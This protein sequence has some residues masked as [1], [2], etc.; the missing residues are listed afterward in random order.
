[1]LVTLAVNQTIGLGTSATYTYSPQSVQKI[2]VRV[3]DAD[4]ESGTLNVQIGSKTIVNSASLWG[5]RLFTNMISGALPNASASK[6]LVIDIGSHQC[7]SQ[8]N[9]YVTLSAVNELTNVDVSAIVDEPFS[10]SA[11]IKYTEYSD[12]TFTATNV[13]TAISYD[14]ARAVVEGDNFTCDIKT[15]LYSSSPNF[16]SANSYY[17]SEIVGEGFWGYG[18]LLVK[19][20][21]PLNTSF[22]YNSSAVTDRILTAELM[23]SS[24]AQIVKGRRTASLSRKATLSSK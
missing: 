2:F 6:C 9:L 20:D 8:D 14:N 22:N 24:H 11:P 15:D 7:I 16:I 1:M 18:G 23:A 21:V 19:H 5:L 12:N 10:G 4:W 3:A 17:Q 13:L